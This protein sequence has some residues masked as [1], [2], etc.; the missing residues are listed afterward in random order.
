V[1]RF[2]AALVTEDKGL[3]RYRLGLSKEPDVLYRLRAAESSRVLSRRRCRRRGKVCW[4]MTFPFAEKEEEGFVSNSRRRAFSPRTR[5]PTA[6]RSQLRI[7]R[8]CCRL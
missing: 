8:R 1:R 3:T 4:V 2:H 6:T 5:F 7:P